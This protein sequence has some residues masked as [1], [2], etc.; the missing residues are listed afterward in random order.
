MQWHLL[1]VSICIFH[2]AHESPFTSAVVEVECSAQVP[3]WKLDTQFPAAQSVCRPQ[4]AHKIQIL[5]GDCLWPKEA[6]S[7]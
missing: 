6:T 3:A 5:Y 7:P 2:V 4:K 1:V